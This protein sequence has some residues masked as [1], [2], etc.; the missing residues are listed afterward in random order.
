MALV[1]PAASGAEVRCGAAQKLTGAVTAQRGAQ[2]VVLAQGDAVYEG[3]VIKSGGDGYAEI[4]LIDDTLIAMGSNGVVALAEVQFNVNKSS[5]HMTIE[6]GA[7]WVSTGSI[8][9]VS[10][11]A[12]KFATPSAVVSSGNATLHFTVGGGQEEVKVQWIPKGG[13]VSV[14]NTKT[15]QRSDV[16]ESEVA[17]SISAMEEVVAEEPVPEADKETKAK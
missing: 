14:Y 2:E 8:G 6:H 9:L 10:S 1:A 13:N 5:L 11:E 3:D 12:V 4:K 7:I 17:F 15:K 16:K